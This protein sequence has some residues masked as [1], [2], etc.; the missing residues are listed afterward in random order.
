MSFPKKPALALLGLVIV[1]VG[2]TACASNSGPGAGDGGT[3]GTVPG[4]D[5]G[6]TDGGPAGTDGGPS[7]D[8]GPECA[9]RTLPASCTAPA[10]NEPVFSPDVSGDFQGQLFD[11]IAC[12]TTSLDVAIYRTSWDCI[13]DALVAKLTADPDIEIRLVIDDDECPLDAGGTRMCPLSRIATSPRVTIVDDSR[14]GLMHHKFIIAD[15]TRVWTSSANFSFASFCTDYNN[16]I[17]VDQAEI[18]AGFQAEL[19]RHMT[20]AFGPVAPAEPITGGGWRLYFSPESPTTSPSRWFTDL[21]AAIDAATTSIEILTNAWTRT[22]V[23][24][25][26]VAAR[27]RGVT[28]RAL[29]DNTYVDDAPAQALLAAGIEVRAENIHHKVMIIDG[30]RVIMGSANWSQNSWSNNE[31]SLWADD[32]AIATS[33]HA[34]FE[35][36]WPLA[37]V[38]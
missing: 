28:V 19:E 34:E 15:G 33:F 26:I 31:T 18:V 24:D 17:I 30:T 27:A 38:P 21:I 4:I 37:T 13:V 12:A 16:A 35:R 22:E 29:V 2:L 5:G 8:G 7:T 3:D 6:P 10:A 11:A 20:G 1:G 9:C 36:I 14:S 32:P 25:A 23:S